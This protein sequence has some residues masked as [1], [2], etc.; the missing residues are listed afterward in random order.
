[1]T[2]TGQRD[3][4]GSQSQSQA[5]LNKGELSPTLTQQCQP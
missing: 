5:D 2:M 4:T 3:E 1:M